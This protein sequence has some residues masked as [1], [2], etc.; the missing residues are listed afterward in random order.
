MQTKKDFFKVG[1]EK[2]ERE[3]A[4]K[5]IPHSQIDVKPLD[6]LPRNRW[7]YNMRTALLT[8]PS[9]LRLCWESSTSRRRALPEPKLSDGHSTFHVK[10]ELQKRRHTQWYSLPSPS[11][12]LSLLMSSFDY[13]WEHDVEASLTFCFNNGNDHMP[14]P[15]ALMTKRIHY[16]FRH[17]P[18][19]RTTLQFPLKDSWVISSWGR[20]AKL[21]A[22]WIF[23]IPIV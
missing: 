7:Y 3:R 5:F 8:D 13:H 9:I 20:K 2:R 6:G 15:R 22:A 10:R 1:G 21:S 23:H 16:A 4:W 17:C 11:G 12:I 14:P 18:D 19:S